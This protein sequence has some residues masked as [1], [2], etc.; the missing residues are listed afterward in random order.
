MPVYTQNPLAGSMSVMAIFANYRR[1]HSEPGSMS[2]IAI[3]RQL[4]ILL[5][6]AAL[7]FKEIPRIVSN[8]FRHIRASCCFIEKR[9]IRLTKVPWNVGVQN[10]IDH[11]H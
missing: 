2:D 6:L 8:C 1:Y 9:H 7:E 4:H 5:V 11:P 3:L 10:A